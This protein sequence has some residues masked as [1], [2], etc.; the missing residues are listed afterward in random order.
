VVTP[1]PGSTISTQPDCRGLID[2]REK[3]PSK[4]WKAV[5]HLP[6]L[7][8]QPVSGCAH[9][10]F[11]LPLII[12]FGLVWFM[13]RLELEP[14]LPSVSHRVKTGA[15]IQLAAPVRFDKTLSA[16]DMKGQVWLPNVGVHGV[17][18]VVMSIR[19]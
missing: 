18:R 12:F 4:P 16:A 2:G 15:L 11:F 17:G 6:L 14:D 10:S 8:P 7:L 9:G 13:A 5:P 3:N 19:C 1:A